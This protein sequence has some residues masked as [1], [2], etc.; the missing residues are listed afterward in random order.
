MDV[1]YLRAPLRL[2]VH[3]LVRKLLAAAGCEASISQALKRLS[4]TEHVQCF[5]CQPY[6][7][8]FCTQPTL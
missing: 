2:R 3:W 7:G 8:S 1:N 4:Q 5:H 6:A